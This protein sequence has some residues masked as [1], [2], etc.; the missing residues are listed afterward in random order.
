MAIQCSGVDWAEFCATSA[1][2]GS[3]GSSHCTIS[4]G[5]LESV[6]STV[7]EPSFH[8][9]QLTGVSVP[10]RHVQGR[11][12]S[13]VASVGEPLVPVVLSKALDVSEVV[14]LE[15]AIAEA[16]EQGGDFFV[17]RRRARFV[18]HGVCGFFGNLGREADFSTKPGYAQSDE[19]DDIS[20]SS[21]V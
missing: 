11:V 15:V 8:H 9:H 16:V 1:D 4:A 21:T 18:R 2:A 14:L 12:P 20:L 5:V 13:V 3:R 10:S 17:G 19:P 6:S 7:E